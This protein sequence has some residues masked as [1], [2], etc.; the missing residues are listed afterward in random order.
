MNLI[1]DDRVRVTSATGEIERKVTINR[2][3][4]TGFINIP[5]A[6]NQNDARCLIQL[7]PLL[8]ASSSGW[9]SCQVTVE[10]VEDR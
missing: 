2:N 4:Q 10:K 7:M 8:D 3:I 5:T 6:Y 1:T 9:D